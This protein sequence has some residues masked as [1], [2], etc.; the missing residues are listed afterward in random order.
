MFLWIKNTELKNMLFCKTL[1]HT[2]SR[3]CRCVKLGL[4]YDRKEKNVL[5]I[6]FSRNALRLEAS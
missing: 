3:V 6:T 5:S 1:N 2:F 4:S